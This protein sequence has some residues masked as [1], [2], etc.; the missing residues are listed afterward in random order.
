MRD[1]TIGINLLE[2][3]AKGTGASVEYQKDI[4]VLGRCDY[5]NKI[6][7]ISADEGKRKQVLILA[8][9]VG[10]WLS[11]LDHKKNTSLRRNQREAL[12]YE[13]GWRIL[14][15]TG[16]AKKYVVTKEEW[17]DLNLLNYH[18]FDPDTKMAWT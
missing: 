5:E 18:N 7:Y 14:V 3:I 2:D 17:Q 9:E 10:H 1:E 4:P 12:A 15:N 11:F 13:Y 8:H 16:L 6:I